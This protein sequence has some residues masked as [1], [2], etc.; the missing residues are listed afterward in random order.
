MFQDYLLYATDVE[1]R[2]AY[3]MTHLSSVVQE[4]QRLHGLSAARAQLLGETLVAGTLLSSVLDE[5]ERINLRI[6]CGDDF[7]IASET[8]SQLEMRGY[9]A[10]EETEVTSAVDS[11][12]SLPLVPLMV[13]TLRAKNKTGKLFEGVTKFLTN[14]IEEAVNDHMRHSYQ[15]RAQMKIDCWLDPKDQQLHAFGA[16]FFELPNLESSVS[17]KL[18]DH[19]AGLPLL[20]DLHT[21]GDDPDML[22]AKLIPDMTRP[23]RSVKPQWQCGCS[24]ES[25]ERM[26]I[27]LPQE[28]L[29]DM[30]RKKEPLEIK[31]HYCSQNYSVSNEKQRELLASF[32]NSSKPPMVN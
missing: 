1:V 26:L 10:A 8:T 29:Q 25:V 24:Q 6:Q 5:E 7:T 32:V 22:A 23:V 3:R 28:E 14:S 27:S 13:R 31:C 12:G 9:L 15:L 20:R 2:Y 18:W 30:V 16:I 19:V 21:H 11:T 17:E 4:A